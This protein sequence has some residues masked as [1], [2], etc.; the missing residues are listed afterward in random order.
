MAAFVPKGIILVNFSLILMGPLTSMGLG[1]VVDFMILLAAISIV[2]SVPLGITLLD[3][4]EGKWLTKEG[5]ET[6]SKA[7]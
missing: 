2:A 5:Q 6:V 3:K 7:S 4:A 1:Y